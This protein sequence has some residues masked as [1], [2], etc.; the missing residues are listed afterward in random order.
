MFVGCVSLIEG[1]LTTLSAIVSLEDDRG[2]GDEIDEG[3]R[4]VLGGALVAHI[5]C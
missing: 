5:V 4:L 1:N 3:H 2:A